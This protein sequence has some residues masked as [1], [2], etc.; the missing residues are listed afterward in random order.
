MLEWT[1]H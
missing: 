1:E